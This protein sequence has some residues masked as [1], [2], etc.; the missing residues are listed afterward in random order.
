MAIVRS[1]DR[2]SLRLSIVVVW[3]DW[4]LAPLVLISIGW[5]ERDR[6][7]LGTKWGGDTKLAVSIAMRHS[8]IRT[9]AF[10]ALGPMHAGGCVPH[11]RRGE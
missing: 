3:A 5:D 11:R 2:S 4:R 6:L 9:T 8:C 10:S 1:R 7:A